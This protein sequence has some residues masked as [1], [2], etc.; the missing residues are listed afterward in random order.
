MLVPSSSQNTLQLV[1]KM[2]PVNS[3]ST[4]ICQNRRSIFFF[5][6]RVSGRRF[7]VDTG[8]EIRVQPASFVNRRRQ[9]LGSP[10]EEAHSS[11]ITAYGLLTLILYLGLRNTQF[12]V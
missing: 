7:L 3:R 11:V 4:R 5:Q 2:C 6:D 8:A 1:A 9:R 10:L 12:T